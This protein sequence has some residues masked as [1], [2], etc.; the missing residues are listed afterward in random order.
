MEP[1]KH[2]DAPMTRAQIAGFVDQLADSLAAEP[3]AWDNNT[4][5]L[6]LRGL[7][8]W[9]G[10]MDGYFRNRGEPVPESPSWQLVAAALLAAR[11]YE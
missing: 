11:I 9:L 2:A 1:E 7:A 3:D 4:L 6:F 5:D 10:D 8:G